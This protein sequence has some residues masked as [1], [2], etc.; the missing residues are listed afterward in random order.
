LNF[1]RRPINSCEQASNVKIKVGARIRTK[2]SLRED[3]HGRKD[4][5][6]LRFAFCFLFQ[7]RELSILI[8][9]YRSHKYSPPKLKTTEDQ[10]MKRNLIVSSVIV[11]FLILPLSVNAGEKQTPS[12]KVNFYTSMQL[13]FVDPLVDH[14]EKLYPK[15]NVEVFYSGAVE[16]AQRVWAEAEADKIRADVIWGADPSFAMQLKEKGLLMQ[17]KSPNSDFVPDWLKDKENYYIAGRVFSMGFAYNTKLISEKDVPKTWWEFVEFGPKAAMASPLH[18]GTSFTTLAAL[19]EDKNYGWKWWETAAAKGV[20]VLRG[21]GDVTRGLISGEFSV[22]K[23][24]DYVIGVH[25]AEGA[26]VAYKAPEDGAVA[27][28]SPLAIPASAPNPDNA[29]LFVDYILSK[30]GQK[31]LAEKGYLTPVRDDVEPPPGF[32]RAGEIK[33][34][35]IPYEAM[36]TRGAQIRDQFR[37]IYN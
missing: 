20:K 16:M 25:A 12:G 30:E 23:G 21:T 28:Q 10:I 27:V 33:S 7:G 22:I 18:S 35:T 11:F 8:H 4:R 31:F 15:I 32:P 29:K 9:P 36:R 1:R 3:L 13:D 19:V 14:F 6:A 5:D 17:Y 34:L 26:P 24:I 2:A 37:K